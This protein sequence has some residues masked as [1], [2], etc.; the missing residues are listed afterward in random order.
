M[1]SII[2][3]LRQKQKLSFSVVNINWSAQFS[4]RRVVAGRH[5][6]GLR[7]LGRGRVC[8]FVCLFDFQNN[9]ATSLLSFSSERRK[10]G[11]TDEFSPN[12]PQ[13]LL[14]GL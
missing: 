6:H 10:R 13:V 11:S 12:P 5:T 8:G 1:N 7:S 2:K 14:F 9:L 4:A 3:L